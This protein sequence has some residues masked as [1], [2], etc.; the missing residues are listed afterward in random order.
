MNLFD[1]VV[2]VTLVSAAASGFKAGLLRSAV[3]ILAYLIAMPTAVF[4]MSLFSADGNRLGS[5]VAQGSPVLFGTFLI[6]GI[7]LSKFMRMALE[8]AIGPDA[9]IADRLAGAALATVRTSLVAIAFVLSF[10][11]L[12][13]GRQP[14]FLTGSLLRPALAAAGQ[15]GLSSLPPSVVAYI[16]R[17]KQARRI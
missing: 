12:S 9:G 13:S 16:D 15:K 8:D 11:Q 17:L 10:D 7:M 4:L 2:C 6:T 5:T 14:A 3:T 1:I